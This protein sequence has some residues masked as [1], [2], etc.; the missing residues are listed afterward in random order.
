MKWLLLIL[1]FPIPS[2]ALTMERAIHVS[3]TAE[4][5][6]TYA[7]LEHEWEHR[8]RDISMQ[9]SI[10]IL[11]RGFYTLE[12]QKEKLSLHE[13]RA[14]RFFSPSLK[15]VLHLFENH[16]EDQKPVYLGSFHPQEFLKTIREMFSKGHHVSTWAQFRCHSEK[17]F[18]SALIRARR[19]RS[20]TF[21]YLLWCEKDRCIHNPDHLDFLRSLKM[22]SDDHMVLGLASQKLYMELPKQ[23]FFEQGF[24]PFAT[25]SQK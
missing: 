20:H 9:E 5:F 10:L 16:R 6:Q 23:V 4:L 17:E 3:S 7:R 2:F 8:N 14:N 19:N 15:P 11:N 18:L 25:N 22:E 1:L 13:S 12:D 24:E 21:I